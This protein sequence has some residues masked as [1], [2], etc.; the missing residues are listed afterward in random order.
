MSNT[1]SKIILP[2]VEEHPL[3]PFLPP[4]ARLLMLGSFP[5]QKKRWCME[6]Y[7]PNWI[8]DMWRIMGHIFYGNRNEFV[9]TNEKTFDK[10]KI[11]GF[12]MQRGIALYDT[13]SAVRRLKDNAS[14]KFL[15]VV[16][17]T[18][19]DLLLRQIPECHTIVTTGEKATETICAVLEAFAAV[20]CAFTEELTILTFAV[21]STS[22]HVTLPTPLPLLAAAMPPETV[23]ILLSLPASALSSSAVIWAYST[24][25][26]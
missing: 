23:T 10:E 9:K 4:H 20:C 26:V 16:Q 3:E 22:F 17:P 7:Y 13:A 19:L 18:D 6:F 25:A 5:P 1:N 11:I 21:F 12:L 15:E 24:F 2:E 8:N 14:D